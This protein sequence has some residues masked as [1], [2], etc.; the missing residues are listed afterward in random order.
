MEE[1]GL[2]EEQADADRREVLGR[3]QDRRR[4]AGARE[5]RRTP[6]KRAADRA[7]MAVGRHP[8][9]RRAA[10]GHARP[11]RAGP[12][13]AGPD[14]HRHG[15]RRHRRAAP[16]RGPRRRLRQPAC[17]RRT[18]AAAVK[19]EDDAADNATTGT[20]H[21]PASSMRTVGG[22]ESV[23]GLAPEVV[24]HDAKSFAHGVGAQSPEEQADPRRGADH[25]FRGRARR[26]RARTSRPR[27][28]GRT[29]V[30]DRRRGGLT[31][32]GG[33]TGRGCP[34]V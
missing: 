34:T 29:V 21:D 23:E 4:R 32:G 26:T 13:R 11:R 6:S 12:R 19:L 18:P 2:S 7:A 27:T 22:M 5:G 14:G 30:P 8:R 33:Q 20:D 28:A 25:Q 3:G 16:G 24:T 1:L 9:L 15:Q 17:C 10:P 31:T